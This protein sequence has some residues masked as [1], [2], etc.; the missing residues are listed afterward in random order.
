MRNIQDLYFP[1]TFKRDENALFCFLRFRNSLWK[2]PKRLRMIYR[3]KKDNSIR[4]DELARVYPCSDKISLLPPWTDA[5]V[6]IEKIHLFCVNLQMS[7]LTQVWG[8]KANER[9]KKVFLN[10]RDWDESGFLLPLN[11]AKIRALCFLSLACNNLT[12]PFTSD[13]YYQCWWS[14]DIFLRLATTP[15]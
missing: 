2:R 6:W 15:P 4:W 14:P 11:G 7:L 10:S 13:V 8:R 1:F 5:A 3:N 12:F 9:K